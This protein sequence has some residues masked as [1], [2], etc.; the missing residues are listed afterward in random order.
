[1]AKVSYVIAKN[2]ERIEFEGSTKEIKE[3]V[4]WIDTEE[5]QSERDKFNAQILQDLKELCEEAERRAKKGN[6]TEHVDV[7]SERDK[8]N[9][10]ILQDL[11]ELCEEA[12]RRAKKGNATETKNQ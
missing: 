5:N 1:M 11:K 12:E 8:F 2:S 6:A 4:K 3:L 7:Q 10:Q 9:A